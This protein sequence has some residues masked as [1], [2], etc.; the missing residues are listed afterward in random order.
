[1][2]LRLERGTT[3]NIFHYCQQLTFILDFPSHLFLQFSLTLS[4]RSIL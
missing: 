2:E 3:D 4:A 1:M